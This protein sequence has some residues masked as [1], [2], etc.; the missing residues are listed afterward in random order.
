MV[1][2]HAWGEVKVSSVRVSDALA[3]DYFKITRDIIK[4]R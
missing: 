3:A 4:V 2:S 1:L